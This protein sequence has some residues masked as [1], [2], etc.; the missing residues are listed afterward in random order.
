MTIQDIGIILVNLAAVALVALI[1]LYLI[2]DRKRFR[3][4]RQYKAV[5]NLLDEWVR[6]AEKIPGCNDAAAA[7][8]RTHSVSEKYRQLAVLISGTQGQG[9]EQMMEIGQQLD[10][11]CQV[12]EA[13]AEPYNRR[14]MGR[15]GGSLLHFLGFREFPLLRFDTGD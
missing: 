6:Q 9:T 13:L 14:L 8:F 12:Y 7:Y 10:T 4:E 3:V 15:I 5:K 2:T 11:F 1:L